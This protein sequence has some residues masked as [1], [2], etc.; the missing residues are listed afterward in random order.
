[1]MLLNIIILFNMTLANNKK[2]EKIVIIL[3]LI[4]SSIA[5]I[6]LLSG[7]SS[8]FPWYMPDDK[9][10]FLT[11][12]KYWSSGE[13]IPY[14]DLFDH[15]GPIIFLIDAIGYTIANGKMFGVAIVEIVFLFVSE[16]FAFKILKFKL[17]TKASLI[18]SALMPLLFVYNF[19]PGNFTEE[20]MLPFLFVTFYLYLKWQESEEIE[21]NPKYAFIYG[22]A[23]GFSLMVRITNA[24]SI[25]LIVSVVL[26]KLIISKKW[27]NIIHNAISFIFGCL[28]MVL[29]FV[30]YFA[31]K[32]ALYDMWYAT[33]L[34]NF[35]YTANSGLTF[36][37][38]IKDLLLLVRMT[39]AGVLCTVVCIYKYIRTKNN[40]SLVWL[41][42]CLPSTMFMFM[43]NR[44]ANYSLLLLPFLY[45]S[46]VL[47]DIKKF[48]KEIIILSIVLLI[49]SSLV[50]I[51]KLNNNN[52]KSNKLIDREYKD[53]LKN[54]PSYELHNNFVAFDPSVD[55]YLYEEIKPCCKYFIFQSWQ[56][57]NS[58]K[59]KKMEIDEFST[60]NN[61]HYVMTCSSAKMIEEVLSEKYV[62]I[63]TVSH[64]NLYKRIK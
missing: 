52:M 26:I 54:I 45:I 33:L 63:D 48:G 37:L 27:N 40:E 14:V 42:I 50:K 44:Y 64:Y 15:K 35:D 61:I 9:D 31:K 30:I 1:M 21:H 46:F 47:V 58:D 25:C 19:V 20:Y 28:V 10:I 13:T 32:N 4:A 17:S 24:L 5:G 11:I 51:N 57:S 8:F 36:E 3:I 49:V 2:T 39:F 59:L 23:F 41:I 62:L 22:I 6:L 16:Y 7:C 18:I 38:T 56:S 29:P 34:Y 55:F 12:G 60:N 43:L 53:L